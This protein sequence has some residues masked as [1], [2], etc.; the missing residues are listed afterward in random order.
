MINIFFVVCLELYKKNDLTSIYSAYFSCLSF[1]WKTLFLVHDFQH[2]FW[3]RPP[4]AIFHAKKNNL[5]YNKTYAIGSQNNQVIECA[6][7]EWKSNAMQ[8]VKADYGSGSVNFILCQLAQRLWVASCWRDIY[9][10]CCCGVCTDGT[11]VSSHWSQWS[12][13]TGVSC[14]TQSTHPL[15]GLGNQEDF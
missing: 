4:K 12:I 2:V 15:P 11:R 8:D 5:F 3:W 6:L 14:C 7:F 13:E 10:D 1:N 9:W